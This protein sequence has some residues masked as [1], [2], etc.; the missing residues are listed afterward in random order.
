M[1][2]CLNSP[3][4]FGEFIEIQFVPPFVVLKT[5]PP[6]THTPLFASSI[7]PSTIIPT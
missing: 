3:E 5:N 7:S 2:T 4:V 1:L 6:D